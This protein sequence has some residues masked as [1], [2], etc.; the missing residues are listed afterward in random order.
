MQHYAATR[1]MFIDVE[2]INADTRLVLG[3]EGS[4]ANPN[5][6]SRELFSLYKEIADTVCKEAATIMVVFPS[7]NEVMSI[8]VQQVLEQR[9]TALL[10]ILLV[11]IT[12]LGEGNSLPLTSNG[13]YLDV[14]GLTESLFS[15]HKDGYPEHEQASFIQLY[16]AKHNTYYALMAELRTESQ[17]MSKSSGTIGH[18][19]GAAASSHNRCLNQ[20][21]SMSSL[22]M[23]GSSFVACASLGFA[24]KGLNDKRRDSAEKKLERLNFKDT[25]EGFIGVLS[26]HAEVQKLRDLHQAEMWKKLKKESTPKLLTNL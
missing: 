2:V 6:V 10:D 18:S 24:F 21:G 1:P 26:V 13:P 14:E 23:L 19:K 20:V 17:Q 12:S 22:T 8:L 15:A 9:I 5:N 16:Q 11:D 3:D 7:P 25:V 4:Q